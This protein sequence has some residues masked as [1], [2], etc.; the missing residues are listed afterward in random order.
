MTDDTKEKQEFPMR[1][2][3]H[4][5]SKIIP[6]KTISVDMCEFEEGEILDWIN[7]NNLTY[8]IP[9]DKDNNQVDIQFETEED[10]TYFTLRWLAGSS[11]E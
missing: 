5:G 11:P 1:L 4:L 3:I 6:L 10:E 8:Q 9:I 2:Q 7:E